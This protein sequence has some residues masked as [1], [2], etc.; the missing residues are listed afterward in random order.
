MPREPRR[1]LG[2][3]IMPSPCM[4]RWEMGVSITEHNQFQP[5]CMRQQILESKQALPFFCAQLTLGQNTAQISP[6]FPRAG[7]GNN[8]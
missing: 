3:R 6:T 4:M 5:C 2:Q 1:Q 8:L 7:E